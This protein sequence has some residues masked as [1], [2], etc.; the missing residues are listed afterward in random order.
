M[1]PSLSNVFERHGHTG[2]SPTYGHKD[3]YGTGAPLL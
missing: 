1:V 2:K 3:D